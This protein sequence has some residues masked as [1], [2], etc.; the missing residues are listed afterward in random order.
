MKR[1]NDEI[2]ELF[3]SRLSNTEMPLRDGFWEELNKGVAASRH[4]HKL[5][6]L[7]M[8]AAA[9][10]LLVLAASSAAFWYF[11]PKEEIEEAFTQIA[12][13]N[14]GVLHGDVV[15]QEFQPL[16]VQPILQ[17]PA[18][19][20][21]ARFAQMV[22][23]KDDSTSV[24]VSMSF[25]FSMSA[26][27]GQESEPRKSSNDRLWQARNETEPQRTVVEQESAT[28]TLSQT[29]KPRRWAL[30]T[31][32]GTALP[33]KEGSSKLPITAG[34]TVERQLNNRLALE[35]GLQYTY[36]PAVGAG[37]HY[38]GIPLKM[39]IALADTKKFDFYATVGGLIDK[40]MGGASDNSFQNEPLQL[41]L[42]AGVGVNYQVNDKIALFAEPGISYHFDT[43]SAMKTLRTERP[44]N[45]NLI[46][47]LRMTY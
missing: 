29:D 37:L 25:S 34:L 5:I 15:K 46:C 47:G 28:A 12:V 35:T 2:T 41:A 17:K 32:V 45:F 43:R 44:T 27:V 30:K 24:T 16:P 13:A 1:E 22:A 39:N 18:S 6:L 7:R 31:A 42:T 8:T 4:H 26:T 36:L 23:G 3:R 20:L 19:P 33:S 10:V 38:L 11:S 21:T 40:C 14:S 9:S